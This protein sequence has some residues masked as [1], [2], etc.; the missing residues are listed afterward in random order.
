MNKLLHFRRNFVSN[1]QSSSTNVAKIDIDFLVNNLQQIVFQIDSTGKWVFL[2]STWEKLTDYP[3]KNTLDTHLIENVHPKDRVIVEEYLQGLFQKEKQGNHSVNIRILSKSDKPKWVVLRASAILDSASFNVSGITGTLTEVTDKIRKQELHEAKYRSLQTL[4][5]NYPGMIYRCRNDQNLTIE[6][7][8][9]ACYELTGYHHKQLLQNNKLTY[10]NIIHHDDRQRVLDAIHNNLKEGDYFELSHR[11][12]T[13]S[14]STQWVIN[15]GKGNFSSSGELLSFDGVMINFE[16]KKEEQKNLVTQSL[17]DPDS[18]LL[19]KDLFMNRVEHAI[20]KTKTRDN[21]VFS[22]LLVSIDQYSQL[23]EN[24]SKDYFEIVF[25]EIRRRIIR[26]L[27]PSISLCRMQENQLGILL[28]SSQYSIKNI[29]AIL[30][31][32][33]AQVQSPMSIQD[34]E[35]YIT[36]SIGVVIG[37]SNYN[38][39]EKVFADAE[40]AVNRA[41]GLGG[42]R[43]ELSDLVTHGKAA[44]QTHIESELEQT[45][46]NDKFLVYWQ[47]IVN[48][49]DSK[50][51]GFEARLVWPHPFRGLLFADQF[52]PS[53]EETQLITPLWEWMLNDASRQ[54]ENWKSTI[55]EIDNISLNIQVTGAT[56]LDTD[57]I[58]RLR[59]KLLKVKPNLCNLVVGVSEDVLLHAPR[60]TE[61]ML[62]PI[63]GKDI[64]LLL[65]CYG[66]ENT[67]LKLLR[68][69]PID[70]I[71][72]DKELIENCVEDQGMLV[73]AISSLAHELN[74][75]V[76]ANE[77]QNKHQLN[78][79]KNSN[80]DFAQGSGVSNPIDEDT[81]IQTLK[82]ISTFN[83]SI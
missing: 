7:I 24:F 50:L 2:S 9:E 64:Q 76:I 73:K 41:I 25:S 74:I 44:L 38:D 75:Y 77:V 13:A 19:N 40:D 10:I 54:I 79:L 11:I 43:Y 28:D 68:D 60:S 57:S 66:S 27:E 62:K 52:V 35:I 8:N 6:H 39:N 53:A 21:Y 42:A 82:N 65:D 16:N 46:R 20:Q 34:N 63:K 4:I 80:V 55:S 26:S 49:N 29:T 67:S 69:M 58:F 22:A 45:L 59:E 15:K 18:K 36:V 70:L 3:I 71:R 37:N 33:Q 12:V 72:L 1:D 14:E 31:Q 5:N 78:I 32:I 51:M 23:L 56:L 83:I 81:V 61:S 48:L 47:P 17:Y 30:S